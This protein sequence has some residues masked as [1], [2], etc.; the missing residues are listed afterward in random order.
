MD[1]IVS[2]GLK[3]FEGFSKHC[4]GQV[5]KARMAP[6]AVV[7]NLD[8]SLDSCL[9]MGTDS[10]MLVMRQL[11][12]QAAPETFHLSLSKQFFSATRM[13]ACQTGPV[14]CDRHARNI[15]LLCE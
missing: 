11:I 12:F 7:K 3:M 2:G 10:V 5:A 9:G 13:L 8:V 4:R 1:V 15:D 6:L 14:T